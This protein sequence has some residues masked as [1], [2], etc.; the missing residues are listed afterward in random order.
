MMDMD[1]T[2]EGRDPQI[3]TVYSV[4]HSNQSIKAF[5][6]LLRTHRIQIL[7]D[8]RSSPYSKYVSQFNSSTIAAIVQQHSIKYLFMGEELGGRPDGDEFYDAEHHVLYGH[9]AASSV[10]LDGI[11]RLKEL[12]RTSR[13][14]IMCS[15]EDPSVCHRHLLVGHVL[16]EQGAK[17]LH[18]RGDGHLQTEE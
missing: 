11:S 4:G 13:V 12:A 16:A 17:V 14:A 1:A 5:L 9:V 3:V 15:E 6:E 8:V 7:I 2:F 18:I 10:F